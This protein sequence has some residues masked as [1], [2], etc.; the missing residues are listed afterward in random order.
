MDAALGCRANVF[1]VQHNTSSKRNA[2][3]V[4]GNGGSVTIHPQAAQLVCQHVMD[5]LIY[6]S[7]AFTQQFLPNTASTSGAD[8]SN[9]NVS[10]QYLSEGFWFHYDKA[11]WHWGVPALLSAIMYKIHI[12]AIWHGVY[13]QYV[14]LFVCY[15]WYATIFITNT[16]HPLCILGIFN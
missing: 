11:I 13:I 16:C 5:T 3:T 1:Q 2:A 15:K 8:N 7:K 12:M 6:L 4:T 9:S 14:V 10:C